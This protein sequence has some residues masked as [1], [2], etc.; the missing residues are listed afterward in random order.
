MWRCSETSVLEV[1]ILMGFSFF[2]KIEKYNLA[3]KIVRTES[4]LVRGILVNH[5]F[6]EVEHRHGLKWNTLFAASINAMEE[7]H[8][9]YRNY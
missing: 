8:L 7:F 5:G 2:F 4:R 1:V 3:F 6:H 9:V